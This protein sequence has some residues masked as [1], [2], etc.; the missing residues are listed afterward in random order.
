MTE[1]LKKVGNYRLIRR[2]G[3]GATA[4]VFEGRKEGDL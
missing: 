2:I 3:H 1:P 4:E